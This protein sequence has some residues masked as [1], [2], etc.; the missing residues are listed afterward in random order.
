MRDGRRK[1]IPATL[2]AIRATL[3]AARVEFVAENGDEPGAKLSP[4]A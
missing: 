4:G 3:E 1:P 2:A